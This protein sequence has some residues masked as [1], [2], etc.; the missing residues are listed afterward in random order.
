MFLL[1][2]F[3]GDLYKVVYTVLLSPADGGYP[4]SRPRRYTAL[5]LKLSRWKFIGDMEEFFLLFCRRVNTHGDMYAI[6]PP[7]E[8]ADALSSARAAGHLATSFSTALSSGQRQRLEM[9][10]VGNGDVLFDLEQTQRFT[11]RGP[12]SPCLTRSSTI[13]PTASER[14]LLP[15]EHLFA[16]GLCKLCLDACS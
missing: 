5:V 4:I 11:S 7:E 6:A 9:Q 14:A 12:A 8:L 15:K 3:L 10:E 16:Q 2:W 13:W 1:L